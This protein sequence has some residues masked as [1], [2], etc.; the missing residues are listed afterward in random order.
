M[1]IMG[2]SWSL[3][4]LGVYLR[5]VS[6]IIGVVTSVLMFMSPIFIRSVRCLKTTAT[7]FT[8]TH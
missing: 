5:D 8:S 6:Q 2:L 3:A 7:F 4:S 1:F